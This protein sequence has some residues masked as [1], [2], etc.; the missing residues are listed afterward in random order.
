MVSET[1]VCSIAAPGN[2]FRLPL[3]WLEVVPHVHQAQLNKRYAA[4]QRD[5]SI[6]D[7]TTF[8]CDQSCGAAQERR[9]CCVPTASARTILACWSTFAKGPRNGSHPVR[10]DD[11]TS[12]PIRDCR[13]RDQAP[14]TETA[15]TAAETGAVYMSSAPASWA[16]SAAG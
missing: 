11:T 1:S 7:L 10:H 8:G 13:A 3:S 5:R 6:S 9:R 14:D 16:R 15:E 12:S 4:F 2:R